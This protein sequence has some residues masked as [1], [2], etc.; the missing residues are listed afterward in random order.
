[1]QNTNA[2]KLQ[3]VISDDLFPQMNHISD[4]KQ[5]LEEMKSNAQNLR[6][7]QM[8]ALILLNRMGENEYLHGEKNPYKKL[9]EFVMKG[10][11]F[12]A[13]PEYYIKTIE[14]LIPKPPK[15]IVMAEKA[16]RGKK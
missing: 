2:E 12:V 7:P 15:P 9:V 3:S 6:E 13:D 4:V 11:E 10:K 16:E 5:V 1:M 8:K 14:A